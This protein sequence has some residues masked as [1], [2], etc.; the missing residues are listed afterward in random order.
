V[1]FQPRLAADLGGGAGA[2]RGG[3]TQAGR[4]APCRVES[5]RRASAQ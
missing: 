3:T 4:A 5:E 2:S 1:V